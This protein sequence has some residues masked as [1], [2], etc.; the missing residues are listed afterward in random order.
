MNGPA[1]I[2]LRCIID[3]PDWTDFGNIKVISRAC[4][5]YVAQ[6]LTLHEGL[7]QLVAL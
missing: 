7:F 5:T 4:A 3:R 1:A 2:P 6:D